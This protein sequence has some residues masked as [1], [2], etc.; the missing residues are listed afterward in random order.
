ME[1]KNELLDLVINAH[2]GLER[3]KQC[4]QAK[5]HIATGGYIWTVKGQEGV[6]SD[7]NLIVKLHEQRSSQEK[8]FPEGL[9]STFE[10]KRVSLTTQKG[11]LVEELLNP[12]ETFTGLG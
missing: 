5:L 12:L 6:L 3:W 8:I 2:G 7:L 9:R 11:D 1:K 4:K 10:P